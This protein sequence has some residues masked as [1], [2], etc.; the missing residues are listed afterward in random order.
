VRVLWCGSSSHGLTTLR[1]GSDTYGKSGNLSL[2]NISE[3]AR[4]L[5][6]S[7]AGFRLEKKQ[8]LLRDRQFFLHIGPSGSTYGSNYLANFSLPNQA[9]YYAIANAVLLTAC[10]IHI[11]VAAFAIGPDGLISQ[12]DCSPQIFH[13]SLLSFVLCMLSLVYTAVVLLR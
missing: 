8:K 10:Y 4:L 2:I 6:Y 1:P 11:R 5:S 9:H 13:V 12:R 7:Y 3:P